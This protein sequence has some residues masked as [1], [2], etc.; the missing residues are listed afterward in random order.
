MSTTF[1]KVFYAMVEQRAIDDVYESV[2]NDPRYQ[3]HI[4]AAN[5]MLLELIGLVGPENRE[6]VDRLESELTQAHACEQEHAYV[7]GL[8]DGVQLTRILQGWEDD[9]KSDAVLM[10]F[11]NANESTKDQQ[12]GH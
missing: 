6:R 5:A 7:L 12:A 2:K 10:S 8:K 4:A 9:N 1:N 11:F 3:N